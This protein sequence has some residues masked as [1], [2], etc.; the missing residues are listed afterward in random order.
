MADEKRVQRV[1]DELDFDIECET[2][3]CTR[4]AGWAVICPGWCGVI[5]LCCS[6]HR[7]VLI[8]QSGGRYA[9]CMRCGAEGKLGEEFQWRGL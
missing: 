7:L 6:G 4:P 3:W 8:L 1:L 5:G 9:T 2:V